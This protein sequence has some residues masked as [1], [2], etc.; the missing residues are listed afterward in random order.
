MPVTLDDLIGN[1]RRLEA[2]LPANVRLYFGR[3]LSERPHG[4]R[5]LSYAD[6]VDGFL[7]TCQIALH[8]LIPQ[9]EL[10]TKSNRFGVHSMGAPDHDSGFVLECLAPENLHQIL[11]V[12]DQNR[13]GFFEL[14]R[15]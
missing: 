8:F 14:N 7:Q 6:I 1:E 10:E 4:S 15:K 11:D 5:D 13:R 3:D 2:A 9:R 12:L